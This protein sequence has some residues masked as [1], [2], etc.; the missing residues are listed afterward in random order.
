MTRRLTLVV[1]ALLFVGCGPT[2]EATPVEP[3]PEQIIG[4]V[5]IPADACRSITDHL[6][7]VLPAG[8]GRPA[9]IQVVSSS[10]GD[11]PCP[12]GAVSGRATAEWADGGAPVLVTFEGLAANPRFLV[13]GDARWSGLVQPRSQRVLPGA[14]VPFTLGHCGLLH[15]VDFDGSFW[16]PLG[17]LDP[18][19]P[20]SINS[21]DGQ[22]QLV[23]PNRARFATGGRVIA[24]LA[25]FPG[26]R[27]FW[28]C[29]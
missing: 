15:V 17:Q 24:T 11:V 13:I 1:A 8:R 18:D 27:H 5:G 6:P 3:D 12:P 20:A 19:A 23:G 4:C 14:A 28:L 25:R 2:A 9:T 7:V 16:V 10:C 22:M 21:A 26:P 29:D